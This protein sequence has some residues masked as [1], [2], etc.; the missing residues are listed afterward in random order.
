M[1]TRQAKNFNMFIYP[2]SQ[3]VTAIFR[4]NKVAKTLTHILDF[5]STGDTAFP[6]ITKIGPGKYVFMNYS[7]DITKRNKIW[8]TGQLGKTYIYSTILQ[9]SK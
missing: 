7:S 5:P 4:Y 8:I 2:F 3:K 6:A 9:I 1:N